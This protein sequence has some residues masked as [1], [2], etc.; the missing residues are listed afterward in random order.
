VIY[1]H[2]RTIWITTSL[3]QLVKYLPPTRKCSIGVRVYHSTS[4]PTTTGLIYFKLKIRCL[5]VSIHIRYG[6]EDAV[7]YVYTYVILKKARTSE[8]TPQSLN[9]SSRRGA[10]NFLIDTLVAP[11]A[12]VTCGFPLWYMIYNGNRSVGLLEKNLIIKNGG[13]T[14]FGPII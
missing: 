10:F 12:L 5:S 2:Q 3:G 14:L 6:L 8:C 4:T 7:K 1:S 13:S 9:A 11:R